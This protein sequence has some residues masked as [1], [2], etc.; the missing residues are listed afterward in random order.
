MAD[1]KELLKKYT[2][3]PYPPLRKVEDSPVLIKDENEYQ[4]VV[5]TKRGGRS[6]RFRIVDKDGVSYG[7]SYAHLLDWI[8]NPPNLLTLNTSSRI[9]TLEGKNLQLIERL[10]MEERIKEIHEYN[11]KL[12]TSPENGAALIEKME[13]SQQ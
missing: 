8:F 12:H 11:P 2:S 13:I 1:N 4:A 3:K 10:L 6:L 7:C 5:E 9:F